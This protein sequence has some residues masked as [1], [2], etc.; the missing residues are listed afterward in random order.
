MDKNGLNASFKINNNSTE[1]GQ[2]VP[3][4][5]LSFPESIGE[6]PNHI[7]KGFKKSRN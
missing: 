3:M 5:F 1:I 4:M 7:F 2:A 6:Y